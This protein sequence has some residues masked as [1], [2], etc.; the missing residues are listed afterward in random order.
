MILSKRHSGKY[1]FAGIFL[2]LISAIQ[3]YTNDIL[4]AQTREELQPVRRQVVDTEEKSPFRAG[5]LVDPPNPGSIHVNRNLDYR[6]YTPTQLVEEIFVSK[7]ACHSV[8][9]VTFRAYGWD[10]VGESWI[11]DDFRNL[12]YFSKGD[13]N[14]EFEEGLVLTTGRLSSIEGPNSGSNMVGSP[15]AT[16]G[17]N[18][19]C[20]GCAIGDDDL[21]TLINPMFSEITDVAVL[22]FDFVPSST[23]IHFR[24]VFASE[25]YLQFANSAYNDA[26]GFFVSGPGIPGGKQNI[27]LL[28]ST[29]TST[30]VVSINN[31]NNGQMDFNSHHCLPGLNPKNPEYYIHI[32]ADVA[33]W[34]HQVDRWCAPA[35]PLTPEQEELMAS[36]EFNGR[37][38]ALVATANVIPCETYHM[39]LAIGNA[40]DFA[41]QSGVFLEAYSLDLGEATVTNYGNNIEGMDYVYRGCNTNKFVVSRSYVESSAVNIA[42]NY[43]GTAVNGVDIS[44]Y[45]GGNPLPA[46]VTIPAGQ[47]SVEVFYQVHTPPTGSKTFT[48]SGPCPCNPSLDTFS[49]TIYIFDS[50]DNFTVTPTFSCPGDN[51]NRI[52]VSGSGGS[53]SYETSIDGGVTWLSTHL[54]YINLAPD[55]YTVQVRDSGSCNIITFPAICFIDTDA[56]IWTPEANT[57][58][59]KQN[60]HNYANWTPAVAPMACHIV[61]IPGNSSHYPALEEGTGG[62]C[63]VIYFM[64]GGELARPDLLTY[65]KAYVQMNFDL[66]QPP[67]QQRD[68]NKNLVLDGN[69][70]FDRMKYS[71]AVSATPLARERWYVL[72]SPLRSI[73]TGDLGFGGFPLTFLMKFGPVTKDEQFY[74]VGQWSTPYNT[75]IEPVATKVTDGFAF[76]MYGYGMAGNNTGCF[77]TG[78]YTD[79]NDIPSLPSTRSG[80]SYGLK[81]TNGILELPFFADST[82]LYAHRTQ[83]YNPNTST[84]FYIFDGVNAP[85]EMNK[86]SGKVESIA[87]EPGNGNYRFAPEDNSGNFRNPLTHSIAGL[88]VNDE[89]LVGNPYMSSIDMVEF[90]G[91]NSGYNFF[92]IW[93]GTTFEDY[94]YN[95]GVI[96]PVVPGGEPYVAPLQGFFLKYPTGG[97]DLVFNVSNISVVRPAGNASNLRSAG[98]SKEE[99][100]LRIKADNGVA[101]SYALIGYRENASNA[102]VEKEDVQ[103]LFSPY[104]YVPELYSLSGE[105]PVSINYIKGETIIPLGIKTGRTGEIKLT[106]TGMDNYSK[107]PKI[108]LFDALE[109]RTENLTGKASFTYTFINKET[110]IKN[111]RFSLRIGTSTT[112][113]QKVDSDELKIYGDS[114]GIYVIN[115]SSDPV[116]KLEVYDLQGRM[117][118]ESDVDAGYYPL[119]GY[120]GGFPL[121]VKVTTKNQTK[122]VKLNQVK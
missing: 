66:K 30:S 100:L 68:A 67:S 99:N 47:Q 65:N 89:F 24:Y 58:T 50:S 59:D 79:L 98:E 4:N 38:V 57:G 103:K 78:L 105:I 6:L 114:K 39:K 56:V 41:Y 14:F 81:G 73:L 120:N 80:K 43:S 117:L 101:V 32:P 110:G 37:T 112:G 69:D 92:R 33:T 7:G 60:W 21:E 48:I 44:T 115:D 1:I 90:F 96:T 26:F 23:T 76:Y 22:E 121:V 2:L 20:I 49:K 51:S 64:Q 46:F 82:H 63:D 16:G 35:D 84:F 104:N 36:M 19:Q 40:A 113:S 27:A 75:M 118:Y 71:A 102:Y 91:D 95:A 87:R 122:T 12:G 11:H 29:S 111:G 74:P 34:D 28:P 94:S 70:T 10:A 106:F 25:E 55:N 61:Y 13:S 9:N 116:R 5:S 8:S 88:S 31:V 107:A 86:L 108:E 85:A 52:S 72:S 42:L 93:N 54:D 53:G 119:Q 17:G 18:E 15:A 97:K 77:E 109:N 83:V 62:E 45:P 3:P